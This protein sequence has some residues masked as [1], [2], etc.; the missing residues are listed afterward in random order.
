MFDSVD[1]LTVTSPAPFVNLNLD[2]VLLWLIYHKI[3]SAHNMCCCLTVVLEIGCALTE[4]PYRLTRPTT[5]SV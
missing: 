1:K 5:D 3:L 2:T 4:L